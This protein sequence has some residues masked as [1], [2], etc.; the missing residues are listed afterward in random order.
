MVPESRTRVRSQIRQD[1]SSSTRIGTDRS[2]LNVPRSGAAGYGEP[3]ISSLA[4]EHS[5]RDTGRPSWLTATPTNRSW[6]QSQTGWSSTICAATG[7]ASIRDTSRRSPMK[8]TCVADWVTASAMAWTRPASTGM[9]TRHRTPTETRTTNKTS[10]A[11]LVH[12]FE[13]ESEPPDGR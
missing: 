13:T 3:A 8:R 11:E 6:G 7:D 9:R 1:A 5:T 12:G 2:P 4:T 10:A